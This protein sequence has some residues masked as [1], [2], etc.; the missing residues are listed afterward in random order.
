LKE[1]YYKP[2]HGSFG[3]LSFGN[4]YLDPST[5]LNFKLG[6]PNIAGDSQNDFIQVDGDLTLVGNSNTKA[7]PEFGDCVYRLFN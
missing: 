3:T 2:W 1:L 7:A 6:L 4:A 5:I